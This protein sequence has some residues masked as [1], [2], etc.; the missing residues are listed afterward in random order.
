MTLNLASSN[1]R[2]LRDPSKYA[3]LLGELSNPSMGVAA[4]QE[5]HTFKRGMYLTVQSA[6]H[7]LLVYETFFLRVSNKFL[8][9]QK[10][11]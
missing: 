4:A 8:S 3:R 6:T 10:V 7:P 1:V 2:R 5:T 11:S 9:K